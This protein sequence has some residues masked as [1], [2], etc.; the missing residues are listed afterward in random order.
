MKNDK[1][2]LLSRLMGIA[3]PLPS[4]PYRGI[5][6]L[7][8]ARA[9]EQPLVPVEPSNAFG[10]PPL[11]PYPRIGNLIAAP[12]MPAVPAPTGIRFRDTYF[13]E[14][15]PIFSEWLPMKPGLYAVLVFDFGCDPRPYRPIYFGKA[16]DI[17]QRVT[18]SHEK[19]D[20]WCRACKSLTGLYLAYSVMAD[21]SD[22]ER[23]MVE[24][25]LIKAYAPE[26]NE[27]HNPFGF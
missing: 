16:Q 21:S 22:L 5:S 14:P 9:D 11:L 24:R 26:C 1:N 23:H 20:E 4:S 3:P 27:I 18:R 2:S 7:L 8:R 6:D 12:A 10:A 13:P 25:D 17:A 15:K 19:Y